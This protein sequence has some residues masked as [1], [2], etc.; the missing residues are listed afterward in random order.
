MHPSSAVTE[1]IR[2]RRT[3]KPNMM[4]PVRGIPKE[5]VEELLENANWAPSHGLTEPWRFIIFQ[6]ASRKSLANTL[7]GLYKE[8]TSPDDFRPGKV[9]QLGQRPMEAPMVIAIA[10]RRGDRPKIPEIEEIE[11]VACAVQNMHLSA[12]SQGL[13]AFWSTPGVLQTGGMLSFLGLRDIDRCLGL[14]YLGWPK[15]GTTWPQGKR[16]PVAQKVQWF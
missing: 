16:K 7:Q 6:G 8:H 14:L 10:M 12:T 9:D 2:R 5:L 13:G 4:D 11:A 1:V 3:I 15:V